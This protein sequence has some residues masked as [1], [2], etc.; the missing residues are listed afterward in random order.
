MQC[1]ILNIS[2]PYRPPRPVTG[3]A[4]LHIIGIGQ[5]ISNCKDENCEVIY[6]LKLHVLLSGGNEQCTSQAHGLNLRSWVGDYH[7]NVIFHA[8]KLK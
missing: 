6:V 8:L 7:T 1:G 4:L 3:I 5:E 2:Q